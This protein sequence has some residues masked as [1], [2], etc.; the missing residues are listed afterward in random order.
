MPDFIFLAD[1]GV[2]K[3]VL[4]RIA[5]SDKI[6]SEDFEQ[7]FV[8]WSNILAGLVHSVIVTENFSPDEAD[9]ALGIGLSVWGISEA[10]AKKLVSRAL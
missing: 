1:G 4:S 9:I 10:K 8:I 7:R 2:G 6:K 5:S 3:M